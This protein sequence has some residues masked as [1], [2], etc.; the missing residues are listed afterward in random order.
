MEQHEAECCFGYC[1]RYFTSVLLSR[2]LFL[3]GCFVFPFGFLTLLLVVTSLFMGNL[4]IPFTVA[5]DPPFQQNFE[6]NRSQ[7]SPEHALTI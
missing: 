1:G 3:E 5:R 7:A 2:L 4:K 6:N